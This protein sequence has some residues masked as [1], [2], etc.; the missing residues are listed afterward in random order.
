MK[1]TATSPCSGCNGTGQMTWF[2][3]ASRFQFS[4]TDCPE[5]NGTGFLEVTSEKILMAEDLTATT[6]LTP[7]Q[8]RKFLETLARVLSN[9]LLDNEIIK[10]RGFGRFHRSRSSS[11]PT[12]KIIFSPAKRLL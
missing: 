7:V 11:S 6:A 1:K 8:A 4:Y 2:G 9:T 3:G 12:G 10:L 5:C